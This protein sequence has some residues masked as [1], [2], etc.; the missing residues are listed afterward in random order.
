VWI[1]NYPATS[2][3]FD[4]GRFHQ[5]APALALRGDERGELFRRAAADLVAGAGDLA[6]SRARSW[7]GRRAGWASA[8][9]RRVNRVRRLLSYRSTQDRQ[10]YRQ[11]SQQHLDVLELLEQERNDEAAEALRAHL[12]STLKNLTKISNLLKP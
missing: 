6:D 9:I 4:P 12:T 7:S 3:Q 8:L 5:R 2:V 1:R 11:H 10:R